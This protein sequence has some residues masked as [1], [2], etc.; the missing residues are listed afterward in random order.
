[1]PRTGWAGLAGVVLAL[2]LVSCCWGGERL[3]FDFARDVDPAKIAARDAH[4]VWVPGIASHAL[5]IETGHVQP[6]PGITLLAPAGQWDLSQ[7]GEVAL[8]VRNVGSNSITVHCRVDNPGADGASNSVT[9]SV[10]LE[11]GQTSTLTVNIAGGGDNLNGRLFGMRGY[12]VGPHPLK[13]VDPSAITQ[14]LVFVARPMADH[15]FE[16]SALRA[17]QASRPPVPGVLDASPF[18]PFIDTFGQYKHRDW[19]NKTR[20]LADLAVQREAE[21]TELA[22]KQGPADRD[23]YGGWAGGPQLRVTGFFRT[24]KYQGKWWLVDPDGRLF[25]SYGINC[26]PALDYTPVDERAEW[27]DD[28]PGSRSEFA[29]FLTHGYALQGHYQG[30]SPKSFSFAGA[31]LLRKYGPAWRKICADLVHQRLRNWGLNTIGN[32]SDEKTFLLRRTPYTDAISSQQAKPIEGGTG[33]WGKFPDVFD[34]SFSNAVRQSMA[35]K[36]NTSAGDPWCLGYFC[37]NELSWGED[38]SLA[39]DALASGPE[40]PAKREFLADLRARYGDIARLNQAWGTALASW[41]A[42]AEN[43]VTPDLKKAHDDLAA[44]S[45]RCAETYFRIVRDV[46]RAAAPNHLFLGCRFAW[47][48]DR[49]ARAAAAYCDVVSFNLYRESVADFQFAGGDRPLLIGEFHFGALDR[50]MF[51]AG[52]APVASQQARVQA[53]KDYLT[54]VLQHPLFVGAHWFQ[55]R[56]EPVTGRVLDEENYQIG[57]LD[58]ADTPYPETI[59]ASRQIGAGMYLLRQGR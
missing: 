57:F 38:T 7:Y 27:F 45:G 52:L 33:Y 59:A 49:A 23:A 43:R 20:S 30:R 48:N 32:W 13:G 18:F 29:A 2:R 3:L 17:V 24:E 21:A 22:Q 14:L 12:P 1:L 44:F 35:G 28:F 26:I 46:I 56:D 25:F 42:L 58:V 54:S 41:D 47:V 31:N 50:G 36:S 10:S 51:H 11:V 19:P 53:Y 15:A 37:D 39:L 6:W 9:G 5:R 8:S 34:V 55:W 4:V 16:I 40:Q